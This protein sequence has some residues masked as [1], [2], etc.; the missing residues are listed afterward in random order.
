M[1]SSV[2][3]YTRNGRGE[4]SRAENPCKKAT[5]GT[6]E[7]LFVP[8][9]LVD[10]LWFLLNFASHTLWQAPFRTTTRP[11]SPAHSP[12]NPFPR[13]RKKTTGPYD[14]KIDNTRSGLSVPA[15]THAGL[16]KKPNRKGHGSVSRPQGAASAGV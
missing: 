1:L 2:F 4:H 3:V 10:A 13:T 6:Y 12:R 14:N 8:F 9:F 16:S 7:T 5:V 11:F 15:A